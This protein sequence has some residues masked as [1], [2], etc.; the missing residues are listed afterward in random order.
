MIKPHLSW[1]NCRARV[2]ADP[3]SDPGSSLAGL[4][5]IVYSRPMTVI[6][7]HAY[8]RGSG[9]C[10]VC[11]RETGNIARHVPACERRY[12]EFYARATEQDWMVV[13][14]AAA[15]CAPGI[16]EELQFVRAVSDLDVARVLLA[17]QR[18]TEILQGGPKRWYAIPFGPLNRTA[19]SRTVDEMIR[20]GLARAVSER[21]SAS[22]VKVILSAA[23]VHLRGRTD[24]LSPL[25]QAEGLRFRLVDHPDL[26]DCPTY[27]A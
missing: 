3:G 20:I 17:M 22:L 18:G 23:P 21:L 2:L 9:I 12:A 13:E 25:C 6:Q 24:R 16:P 14:R 8:N 5:S 7:L 11:H 19:L 10:P 26:A 15:H 4:L 1:R 27:L